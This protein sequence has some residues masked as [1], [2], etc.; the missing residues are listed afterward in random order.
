MAQ[1][2]GA[3]QLRAPRNHLRGK[4]HLQAVSVKAHLADMAQAFALPPVAQPAFHA[5]QRGLDGLHRHLLPQQRLQVTDTGIGLA[6]LAIALLDGG[7]RLGV[8]PQPAA[9]VGQAGLHRFQHDARLFAGQR[10]AVGAVDEERQHAQVLLHLARGLLEGGLFLGAQRQRQQVGRVDGVGTQTV[11]GHAVKLLF[12]V[13][14]VSL[15]NH[16]H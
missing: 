8:D 2:L 16:F 13:G 6:Q 4:R 5:V 11:A 9:E 15:S 3:G 1:V 14:V 12:G 10:L 7:D